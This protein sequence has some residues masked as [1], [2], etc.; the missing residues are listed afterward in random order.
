MHRLQLHTFAAIA[1]F[2][3]M[4]VAVSALRF[5]GSGYLLGISASG[6][7]VPHEACVA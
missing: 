5:T 1:R 2:V 7:K 6:R 3:S 4:L